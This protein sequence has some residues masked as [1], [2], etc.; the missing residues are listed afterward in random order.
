[1]VSIALHLRVPG[2]EARRLRSPR[3]GDRQ[4][5]VRGCKAQ[6]AADPADARSEGRP[7]TRRELRKSRGTGPNHLSHGF[8]PAGVS[9]PQ[10]KLSG[11]LT[12]DSRRW[13][14]NPSRPLGAVCFP[15]PP[16]LP[17]PLVDAL[18]APG[19]AGSSMPP[20]SAATS[21]P[22][23]SLPGAT[24]PPR[25]GIQAPPSPQLLA[26]AALR[27]PAPHRDWLFGR[28]ERD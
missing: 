14:L 16:P 9:R 10:L 3:P 18:P 1:M 5:G 13:L 2:G 28:S 21:A 24:P 11:L 17:L 15:L 26:A 8:P 12:S 19:A 27:S 22:P 23:R 25:A 20:Y 7:R 6:A 4:R